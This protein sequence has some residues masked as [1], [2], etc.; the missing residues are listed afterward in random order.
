M[1]ALNG[2]RPPDSPANEEGYKN[3]VSRSPL[4]SGVPSLNFFDAYYHLASRSPGAVSAGS[5]VPSAPYGPA[6][7]YTDFSRPGD[8]KD[9]RID[10]VFLATRG[11]DEPVAR[12]VCEVLKHAVVDNL[13]TGRGDY[14]GWTGRWSDHRAVFVEIRSNALKE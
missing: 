4:P 3:M 9:E 13:I 2:R 1:I 10:F 7:T 5:I 11:D 6:G 14:M 8:E 12:G